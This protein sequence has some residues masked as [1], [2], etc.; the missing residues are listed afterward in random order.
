[1]QAILPPASLKMRFLRVWTGLDLSL[2]QG[3]SVPYSVPRCI[4]IILRERVGT[5]CD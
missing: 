2:V 3:P 1:M 4:G 5:V